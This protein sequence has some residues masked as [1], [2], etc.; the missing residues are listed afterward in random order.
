MSA[1]T[2]EDEGFLGRWSRRKREVA[3]ADARP[4]PLA[5]LAERPAEA[6]V[7]AVAPDVQP[8]PPEELELVEPPSLDLIDKDFQ[9]APWLKQNVPEAWKLAAMRRA[10][11]NDPAIAGFENPARD[12]ALDW[13]TPGGAPGYG[14]LTESD[15]V[16][17]MV[18]GIF[19]EPP[20]EKPDLT[21]AEAA[22]DGMSHQLS[23]DDENANADAAAQET[24]LPEDLPV[25][26]RRSDES[27][28]AFDLADQ[29][30][31]EAQPVYA[32]AQQSDD[33]RD[34]SVRTRKRGGGAIPI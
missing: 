25:A 20:P 21:Q 27:A 28:K 30:R 1:T 24:E 12:Y 29:K 26:I 18:R 8:E 17:E 34:V 15:D 32:A 23:S 13:N 9:L 14:P 7:P 22:G 4:E 19:G 33:P 10:W 2:P 5:P 11:E 3:E 6:P 16:A 31:I